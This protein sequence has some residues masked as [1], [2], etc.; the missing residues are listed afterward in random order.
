MET[1]GHE[2]CTQDLSALVMMTNSL[3]FAKHLG[4]RINCSQDHYI[5]ETR[6]ESRGMVNL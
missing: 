3:M 5:Q 6:T 1:E 4:P 2:L